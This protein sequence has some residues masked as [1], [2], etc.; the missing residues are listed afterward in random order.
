MVIACVARTTLLD[1]IGVDLE[2]NI[3]LPEA[4][5]RALAKDCFIG[6]ATRLQAEGS[7]LGFSAREAAF[8]ALSAVQRAVPILSMTVTVTM[9][10]QKGG[11]FVV[12]IPGASDDHV[13]GRWWLVA[14]SFLL[15]AAIVREQDASSYSSGERAPGSSL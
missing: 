11:Q 13:E 4:S 2:P 6:P 3:P 8:K 10:T 14:G 1:G 9:E 7:R 12:S 15:T 5:F